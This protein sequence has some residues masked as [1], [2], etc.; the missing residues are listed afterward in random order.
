MLELMKDETLVKYR[1]ENITDKNGRTRLSISNRHLEEN[2]DL[3]YYIPVET[4]EKNFSILQTDLS[5]MEIGKVSYSEVDFLKSNLRVY[6]KFQE[7]ELYM[8]TELEL[9][10]GY[11]SVNDH[12]VS[13]F[14]FEQYK[15]EAWENK[16]SVTSPLS[17]E[18]LFKAITK[19]V[20]TKKKKE[21]IASNEYISKKIHQAVGVLRDMFLGEY[22]GLILYKGTYDSYCEFFNEN[23]D[24]IANGF[25]YTM[26]ISQ[27][28]RDFMSFGK[29]TFITEDT[30]YDDIRDAV[31]VVGN[32]IVR[33]A[34]SR[35]SVVRG[36]NSNRDFEFGY[37]VANL[38]TS[39]AMSATFV[40]E[41]LYQGVSNR[42]AFSSALDKMNENLAKIKDIYILRDRLTKY[43]FFKMCHV[44]NFITKRII[45][46]Y[47]Y[48]LNK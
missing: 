42:K 19:K 2:E 36:Y 26:D 29:M 44:K 9:V 4:L 40:E 27:N 7:D 10:N 31:F 12:D 28:E 35:R 18:G 25:E 33:F 23:G 15:V 21:N 14:F 41:K 38:K 20:E 43:E 5:I 3:Q 8:V 39:N 47:D 24:L 17:E 34:F 37:I 32:K 46:V 30:S 11:I 13:E 22:S 48:F 45:N 16:F 1:R 6:T